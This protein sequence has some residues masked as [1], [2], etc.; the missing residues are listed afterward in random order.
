MHGVCDVCKQQVES[1][2]FSI[3]PR[4]RF[5]E[6]CHARAERGGGKLIRKGPTV[7][8]VRTP[9]EQ[10]SVARHESAHACLGHALA[11]WRVRS[12]SISPSLSTSSLI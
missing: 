2:V 5:C 9:A 8:V 7:P 12:M 11:G 4:G 10:R 6:D 1:I 3:E